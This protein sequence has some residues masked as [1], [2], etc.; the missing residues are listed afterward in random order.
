MLLLTVVQNLTI[1]IILNIMHNLIDWVLILNTLAN[2]HDVSMDTDS[3]DM[4][5]TGY[6]EIFDAWIAA[7]VDSTT[8]KWTNYYPGK[9]FNQLVETCVAAKLGIKPL[10]SWISC[11]EP[12]FQAP[13][14]WDVDDNEKEYLQKGNLKR[15][16]V[17]IIDPQQGHEFTLETTRYENVAK[18]T[19]VEWPKYNAWHSSKNTGIDLHYLYHIIG[20]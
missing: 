20:Y 3:Y 18:G 9:H 11:I 2:G 4:T 10:R 17:F 8:V 12:G 19:V 14:H 6:Q 1:C 7:G 5:N 16:T 13:W 15:Y